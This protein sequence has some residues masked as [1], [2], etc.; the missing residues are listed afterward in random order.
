MN[1]KR[2]YTTVLMPGQKKPTRLDTLKGDY[3]EQAIR[4]RMAG[5]RT[6]SGGAA[7]GRHAVHKSPSRRAPER[8][9]LLINIEAKLH[10]GYGKGYERWATVHNLKEAAKTLLFLQ[11]N[12][13]SD[14][15]ELEQK[16]ADASALFSDLSAKLKASEA[17]M[18]EVSE[19]Q[20]HISNYGRT[21]D[22]YKAYRAAGYNKKF[23]AEHEE[24][25]RSHQEAKKFF[26]KLG[27]EKLPSINTLKQEYAKLLSEKKRL[28]SGYREAKEKMKLFI[29]AKS[30]V[31]T[32]LHGSGSTRKAQTR[33]AKPHARNHEM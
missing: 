1:D 27:L 8:H 9:N 14:F 13:V 26:D 4:E 33:D 22:V 31:T 25:I 15:N 11:E 3:T 5:I 18:F 32:I 6:V 28:Y 21:R 29:T 23:R 20:K 17:R 10:Q 7:G 12:G 2:K 19:L 30:N 24:S 16:A